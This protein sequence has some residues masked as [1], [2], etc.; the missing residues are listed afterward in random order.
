MFKISMYLN[1]IF[2]IIF[3]MAFQSNVLSAEFGSETNL[4]IPRYVSLKS[5][6]ANI[7][8]GPSK[9][10]PIYIKYIINN[11]PLKILEEYDDW[12]K[13]IDF[14]NNVGWIHKSLISGDRNGIIVPKDKEKIYL[15]NVVGGKIIGE[16]EIGLIV[17]LS[18]CKLDWCL[19]SIDNYK[20]WIEKKYIWGVRD[21]EQIN[22]GYIQII[23]DNYFR[24]LNLIDNVIN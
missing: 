7:R 21:N 19:I 10:Y 8:V 13:T 14:K 24:L 17:K 9:N 18:K 12:R 23:I 22:I 5:D 1:P 6:E 15:F 2:I 11:F 16:I 4:K 20:G 3:I